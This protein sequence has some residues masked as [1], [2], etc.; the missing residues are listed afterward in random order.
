MHII[1]NQ[2]KKTYY[3]IARDRVHLYGDQHTSINDL[4]AVLMGEHA[5]IANCNRIASMDVIEIL[6]LSINDLIGIGLNPLLAEKVYAAILLTK[7]L[8]VLSTPDSEHIHSPRD[9]FNFCDFLEDSFQEK[10]V[11][12]ALDV[13]NKVIG[14]R[15]TFCG[16]LDEMDVHPR[17]ILRFALKKCAAS[18]VV[19]HSHPASPQESESDIAFAKELLACSLLMKI[20]MKDFVIISRG[21]FNSLKERGYLK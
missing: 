18:F 4:I 17:E 11:V 1:N 21:K 20:P 8:K 10:I 9:A 15:E 3:Q 7:K 2:E 19:V 6:N 12:L 16:T 14:R 5:D 13:K